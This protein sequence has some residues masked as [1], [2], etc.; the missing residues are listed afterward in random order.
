MAKLSQMQSSG[1][2]SSGRDFG[3]MNGGPIDDKYNLEQNTDEIR[4]KMLANKDEDDTPQDG[5]LKVYD[6][7]KNEQKLDDAGK[8][9]TKDQ[10][11]F[12][13]ENEEQDLGL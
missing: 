1:G 9:L 5:F 8:P 13:E 12:R 3:E 2:L 10:V 4:K 7:N 6:E 11:K